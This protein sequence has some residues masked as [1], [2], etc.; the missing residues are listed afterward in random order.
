MHRGI[1]NYR[2]R[3]VSLVADKLCGYWTQHRLIARRVWDLVYSIERRGWR[4]APIV[5]M[6]DALFTGHH[7]AAACELLA[8]R[9]PTVSVHD[10]YRHAGLNFTWL[11]EL[12][13]DDPA[14][15]CQ[16]H[17]PEWMRNKYGLDWHHANDELWR[18]R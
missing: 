7:R 16:H 13:E 4:G 15:V 3:R 11:M 5:L 17:T 8:V 1:L 10:L 6:N 14:L 12:C 2:G 9:P 18:W